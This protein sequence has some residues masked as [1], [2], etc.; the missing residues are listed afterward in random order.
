MVVSS[1]PLALIYIEK[2]RLDLT[3][4]AGKD[5]FTLARDH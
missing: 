2:M 4:K 5:L 3:A 1:P